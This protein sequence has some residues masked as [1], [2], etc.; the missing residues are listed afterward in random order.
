MNIANEIITKYWIAYN[1]DKNVIHYGVTEVGQQTSSGQPLF[2][3][4]DT[5]EEYLIRLTELNINLE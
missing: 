1:E 2:E 4:F 5:E 3:I